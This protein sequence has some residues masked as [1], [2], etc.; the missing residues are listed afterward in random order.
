MAL[1]TL[2][3]GD[4]ASG[5]W[6]AAW[7]LGDGRGGFALIGESSARL[8]DDWR[9]EGDGVELEV[10][11]NDIA[12]ELA[13]GSD[14]LVTV[15]GRLAGRSLE[16]L[17]RRGLREGLDPASCESV[18]DVSAWF[19]PDDGV[20]LVATRPRKARD[21]G[22]EL[23]TVSVFQEGH[24]VP[25]ADPRMST[26]YDADGSP[27]KAGLELWPQ[28]TDDEDD[29]AVRY[30]R[31]AAGEAVGAPATAAAG[32]LSAHARLFRWHSRG[33]EGAGVYL[34]VRPS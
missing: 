16:C 33:N 4:L 7:T 9:L 6:G 1:R 17:G 20:A 27:I 11:G 34:I 13:E 31:R 21:H 3:F 28:T 18:R 10:V 24:P 14:E 25:I 8:T 19:A 30:P 32:A 22:A 23:L 5:T 12:S 29:A 2:T 15:R 26:T